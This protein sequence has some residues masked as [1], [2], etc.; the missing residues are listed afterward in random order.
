MD[1]IFCKIAKKEIPS[2]I[3]YE[4]DEICAFKDVHSRAPVHI[5]I[6]PKKHIESLNAIDE[7]GEEMILKMIMTARNL[8]KGLKIFDGYKLLFNVGKK[9]GQIIEHLHLHLMGGWE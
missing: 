8:A 1:C 7:G 4:D 9:G 5:L 3:I 2:D 6:I